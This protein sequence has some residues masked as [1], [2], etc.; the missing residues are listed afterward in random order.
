V[1]EHSEEL[2]VELEMVRQPQASFA[3]RLDSGEMDV[4][5]VNL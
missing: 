5:D 1:E 4:M 3:I 2:V